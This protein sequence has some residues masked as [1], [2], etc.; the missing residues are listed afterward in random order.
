MNYFY[1]DLFD[2]VEHTLPSELV[3]LPVTTSWWKR[4]MEMDYLG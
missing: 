2:F 1:G 3:A 4:R